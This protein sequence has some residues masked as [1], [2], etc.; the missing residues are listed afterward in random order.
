MVGKS[1][2]DRANQNGEWK[3]VMFAPVLLLGI[4]FQLIWCLGAASLILYPIQINFLAWTI[5]VGVYFVVFAN[6]PVCVAVCMPWWRRKPLR[7]LV[8]SA[9]L[10]LTVAAFCLLVI[11][12]LGC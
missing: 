1:L 3:L 6:L 2:E 5:N 9:I 7:T 10:N 8:L 4:A 12:G 11:I